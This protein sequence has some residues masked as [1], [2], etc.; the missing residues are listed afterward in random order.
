MIAKIGGINGGKFRETTEAE[1][2]IWNEC[3]RFVANCIIYY[4]SLILSSIYKHQEKLGNTEILE[5]IKRFSPIAWCH[6][7]LDGFYQFKDVAESIDLEQMITNLVFDFD[8]KD[9]ENSNDASK[10]PGKKSKGKTPT[11]ATKF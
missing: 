7:I 11:Q 9:K 6:I 5:I 2:A 8:K 3:C 4:S 1:L 10:T